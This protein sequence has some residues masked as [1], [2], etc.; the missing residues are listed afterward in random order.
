MDHETERRAFDR[1]VRAVRTKDHYVP[2]DF[3]TIGG[4]WTVDTW[5]R[6]GATVQL[7]DEGATTRILAQDL[8]VIQGY[9]GKL[10]YHRGD[11]GALVRLAAMI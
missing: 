5:R 4:M 7:M 9:D 10:V 11:G 8:D 3:R 2:R 1:I 6:G